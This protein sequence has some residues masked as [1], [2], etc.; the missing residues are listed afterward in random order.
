MSGGDANVLKDIREYLRFNELTSTLECL[1]AESEAQRTGRQPLVGLDDAR[2]AL[3]RRFLKAFDAGQHATLFTLWRSHLPATL[4]ESEG[5][6]ELEFFLNLHTAVLPLRGSTASDA[7]RRSAMQLFKAFLDDRGSRL[8]Q[9]QDLLLYYSL[10]FVANP[11]GHPAFGALFDPA[12]VATLRHRFEQMLNVVLSEQQPPRLYA[13]CNGGGMSG[14]AGSGEF[15]F[16]GAGGDPYGTEPQTPGVVLRQRQEHLGNFASSIH[17]LAMQLVDTLGEVR[18]GRMVSDGYVQT[19]RDQLNSFDAVLSQDAT[20]RQQRFARSQAQEEWAAASSGGGGAIGQ[21]Q[22]QQQQQQQWQQQQQSDSG[23][24]DGQQQQQ[25]EQQEQ[26]WQQPQPQPQPHAGQQAEW[27]AEQQWSGQGPAEQQQQQQ[28]SEPQ[29]QQWQQPQQ[30]QP[31]WQQPPQASVPLLA[32]A[33]TPGGVAAR[34]RSQPQP[35]PQQR[36]AAAAAP[37]SVGPSPFP[38]LNHNKIREHLA[39]VMAPDCTAPTLRRA[40]LLLQALRWRLTKSDLATRRAELAVYIRRDVVSCAH[41]GNP[42]LEDLLL[43]VRGR[44]GVRAVQSSARTP[45]ASD[46]SA[47]SHDPNKI[48]V[49]E[50]AARLVCA[51]TSLAMGRRYILELSHAV[52]ISTQVLQGE[53]SETPLRTQALVAVHNLSLHG[54]LAHLAMIENGM[55]EWLV[56]ILNKHALAMQSG[57]PDPD[58]VRFEILEFFFFIMKLSVSYDSPLIDD[59]SLPCLLGS[60]GDLARVRLRATSLSL[61]SSQ[62]SVPCGDHVRTAKQ[63]GWRRCAACARY[64][65]DAIEAS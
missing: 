31:Q 19:V 3:L 4:Q 25:Q 50:G 37:A 39:A 44:R 17:R 49:V 58:D 60:L 54:R 30:P 47:V 42:L 22:Q 18:N 14:G 2:N 41:G 65:L 53:T 21:E 24:Y 12:W 63:H 52:D 40:A 7:A 56:G 59:I 33:P 16:G 48:A 10:P 8:S 36:R 6:L 46:A 35:Q 11:A 26:Q 29:G 38:P 57:D 55:L 45:D 1:A 61:P 5:A 28:W 20:R 9:R 51:I 13:L 34:Y 27:G 64:R 32:N 15:G 43:R 62:G 23:G